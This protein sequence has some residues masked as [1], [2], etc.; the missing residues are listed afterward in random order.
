MNAA[1]FVAATLMVAFLMSFCWGCYRRLRWAALG[2]LRLLYNIPP[3]Y[4]WHLVGAI[5]CAGAWWLT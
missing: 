3:V 5:C 4:G 1:H 2:E